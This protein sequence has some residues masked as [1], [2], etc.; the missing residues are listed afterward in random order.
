MI[1]AITATV[2]AVSISTAPIVD[3]PV[4]KPER[5]LLGTY[6]ITAYSYNEG[7]GENYETKSGRTPEPY[8]TVAVDPDVIPLGT[9]LYIEGIGEVRADDTGGAV[10]G[11]VVDLHVGYDET[12][13]FGRIERKVYRI[14]E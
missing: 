10:D 11:K 7:G 8:Y 1:H 5:E 13:S 4:E 3:K 14:D 9:K 2:L 6:E 12:E